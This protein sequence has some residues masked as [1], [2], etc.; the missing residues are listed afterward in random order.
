MNEVNLLEAV[1]IAALVNLAASAIFFQLQPRLHRLSETRP[2]LANSVGPMLLVLAAL[3]LLLGSYVASLTIRFP[4][5]VIRIPIPK[6]IAKD[7]LLPPP[8]LP[9]SSALLLSFS[10]MIGELAQ[11]ALT[12]ALAAANRRAADEEVPTSQP[13]STGH[14]S[15]GVALGIAGYK[16]A[17]S[18]NAG[19]SLARSQIMGV[20]L[21]AAMYVDTSLVWSLVESAS[22]R[23]FSPFG[24]RADRVFVQR[25]ALTALSWFIMTLIIWL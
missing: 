14:W 17:L 19:D 2:I 12:L 20:L 4:E 8:S 18:A 5:H 25:V 23:A 13:L 7:V 1:V 11:I 6:F 24:A 21:M 22:R 9:I 3:S 10:V 16:M 15:L